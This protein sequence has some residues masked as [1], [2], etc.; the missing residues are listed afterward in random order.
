M[1]RTILANS[2]EEIGQYFSGIITSDDYRIKRSRPHPDMVW[3]GMITAGCD[4]PGSCLVVD[5]TKPGIQSG[6]SAGVETPQDLKFPESIAGQFVNVLNSSGTKVGAKCSVGFVGF[7]HMYG[8]A[9]SH[10]FKSFWSALKEGGP[11]DYALQTGMSMPWYWWRC[12]A[13]WFGDPSVT[14]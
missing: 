1:M 3:A 13:D 4:G 14:L 9:Y 8:P 12:R 5:D 6:N 7:I 2:E 10:F 11:V